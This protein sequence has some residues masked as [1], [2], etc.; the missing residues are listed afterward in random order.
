MAALAASAVVINGFYITFGGEGARKKVVDATL[1]LTGQGGSGAN[2]I[3]PALF[4]LLAITRVSS[5]RSTGTPQIYV[6]S[7]SPLGDTIWLQAGNA[8]APADVTDTVRCRIE[9]NDL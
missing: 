4:G 1:T 5:V 2:K 8:T 3:P 6:A 7:P 9:G